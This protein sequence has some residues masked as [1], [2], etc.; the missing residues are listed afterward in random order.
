MAKLKDGSRV[1]GTLTVDTAL[2][3]STDATITGNLI[4]AG[5]TV[6]TNVETLAVEDP[7]ISLGGLANGAA[8]TSNDGKDRGLQLQYYDTAAKTAFMGWDASTGEFA[9]ASNVTISNEV[10][11]A[12]TYGNLKADYFIGNGSSLGSITGANVTGTVSSANNSAYAGIVTGSAQGNIT[13]LGTLTGLT[14]GNATANS[15]FGNGTITTTGDANI[16]GNLTV[17]GNTQL[18]N[19]SVSGTISGNFSGNTSAPG[20]NTQVVFNDNGTSNATAGMTFDKGS[21]AF[22]VAG[23]ISG[24]NLTTAGTLNVTGDS[25]VGNLGASGIVTAIGNVSGGNITTA[26]VVDATGNVNGSHLNAVNSVTAANATI[27]NNIAATNGNVT[28]GANVVATGNVSGNNVSATHRVSTANLTITGDVTGHLIPAANETYDLGNSAMKWRDLYLSGTSIKLG[29]QTITSNSVGTNFTNAIF[30]TS[31]TVSGNVSAGNV[32]GGNLVSANYV[33]GTLTT[34]A[35]PNITSVG[36]LT[37]LTVNGNISISNV[38]GT[39]GILV[40][41]LYYSNGTAWDLQQAAGSSGQIQFNDGNN[42]SASANLSFDGTTNVLTVTGNIGASHISASNTISATGNVSGGNI[43]TAG[44]V[45]ATGNVS[46]SNLTTAGVVSAT[47]NVTGANINTAGNVYANTALVTGNISS[48]ANLNVS[49]ANIGF[50][51]TSNT[52]DFNGA[53]LIDLGTPTDGTDAATKAYV[54]GVASGLTVKDSVRALAATNIALDGSV[55]TVD[56]VSLSNGDRVLV[57]GQT[58]ESE[59]GIYVANTGG[60]TRSEDMNL[61]A[62]FPSAFTFVEEGTNYADTGWVMTTN[63]AITVGTTNI[64][65]TQF[66]GA[67]TYLAGNGI[68]LTGSTFDVEYDDVTIKLNNNGNLYIPGNISL[69]NP[70]IGNA[71][72]VSLLLTGDANISGN[73]YIGG[74]TIANGNISAPNFVGNVIGDVQGNIS[75]N[76]TVSGGAGA[77]QFANAANALVSSSSLNFNTTGNVLTVGANATNGTVSA[78]FLTGTLTTAAQPN[79]TSVGNLTNLNVDGNVVANVFKSDNYQYANGS[80]IDFQTA[81][82]N[83]FEVQF[84]A[85]G[86]NDLAAST[87]LTFNSDTA[88]LSITGNAKVSTLSNTHVLVAG[89]DGLLQGTSGLTFSAANLSVTGNVHASG[90]VMAANVRANNLTATHVTFAGADGLITGSGNLT[91]STDTLST[92]NITATGAANVTGNISAANGNLGNLVT[93]NYVAGTLTTNAQTNITSVGTLTSLAVSGVTDLN[94][95]ANVRIGGATAG[96]YLQA[97]DNAG[98]VTW[99]TLDSSIIANGTSNVTIATANG[100]V[101]TNV[102]GSAILTVSG[103]GANVTGVITATGNVDANNINASNVITAAANVDSTS[104]VTGTV[105]VTGGMSATGNIYTGQSVGFA[106]NNGG[107]ASAAYIQF[108]ASA[109]SLDFIFN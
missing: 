7:L 23:T 88:M 57:K 109:N 55:T 20:S 30:S 92:V 16:G 10:V 40:D 74:V 5:N 56:G 103:T 38:T 12:F 66:S 34:A 104:S 95:V 35:Q 71:T 69:S 45:D 15:T 43:T 60:W 41:N 8:Q 24:G 82:G 37:G 2:T 42:F 47:G 108:N 25:N 1:Y 90:Q 58:T 62:E 13:S 101:V 81:A 78:G 77:I 3:V 100:N 83:S 76:I 6:Y 28:A 21:N 97:V 67:G 68:K 107:T 86:T 94:T 26:G 106:N 46:G 80:P 102:N 14:I 63:G 44:A 31:A 96:Q 98:N 18:A 87:A 53:R 27:T 50:T 49:A 39:N 54:D 99:A 91:F 29:E 36:N 70:N 72:G 75:G 105:K 11:T 22:T 79:I 93:A 61:A 84:K 51:S 73:L 89:T 64:V 85:N 19:L 9:V 4:V 48:A 52:I 32:S 65:W 33:T 17:T 59:N